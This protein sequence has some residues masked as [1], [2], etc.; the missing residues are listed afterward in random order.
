MSLRIH[1]GVLASVSR[2]SVVP[3]VL[4][5]L[6]TENTKSLILSWIISMDDFSL[7]GSYLRIMTDSSALSEKAFLTMKENEMWLRS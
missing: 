1:M 3:S 5:L 4:L 6:R 7:V 2:M